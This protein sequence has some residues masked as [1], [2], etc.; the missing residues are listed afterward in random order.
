MKT[1]PFA[2][3]KNKRESQVCEMY[4]DTQNMHNATT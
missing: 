2:I 4:T 1:G 3:Q